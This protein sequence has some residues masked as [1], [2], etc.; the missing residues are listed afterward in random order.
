MEKDKLRQLEKLAL[1]GVTTVDEERLRELLADD[2]ALVGALATVDTEGLEPLNNPLDI[3]LEVQADE[4]REE[5]QQ[6]ILLAQAPQVMDNHYVVPALM[7]G[8]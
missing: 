5:S 6:Q 8:H 2:I 1:I 3:I 7:A 4:V